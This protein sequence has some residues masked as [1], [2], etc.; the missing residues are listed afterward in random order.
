MKIVLE[1]TRMSTGFDVDVQPDTYVSQM[2]F[3][4]QQAIVDAVDHAMQ[5]YLGWFIDPQTDA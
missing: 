5:H 3:E 2:S 4:D 1:I